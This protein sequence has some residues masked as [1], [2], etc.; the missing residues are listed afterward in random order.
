MREPTATPFRQRAPRRTPAPRAGAGCTPIEPLDPDA[1]LRSPE[2]SGLRSTSGTPSGRAPSGQVEARGTL[3]VVRKRKTGAFTLVELLVVIAIIGLLATLLLPTLS[4]IRDRAKA[5][6]A[7]G[8]IIELG[9][10]ANMYKKATGYFPGQ[11]HADQLAGYTGSQVLAACL[12]DYAYDAIVAGDPNGSEEYAPLQPDD[13]I[14]INGRRNTISDRFGKNEASGAMAILY[15]PS[16]LD[17]TGLGQYKEGDNAAYTAGATWTFQ[18]YIK[19][20]KI[21]GDSSTTPYN[22][23]EFLL[24]AAGTDRQYGTAYDVKNW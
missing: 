9:N 8:R 13:L 21:D 11:L 20:C 5:A 17:A 18:N 2:G 22:D 23:R 7:H 12:F 19:S 14:N 1:A 3:P 15:Y 4:A 16:H 10:G 6:R 24:M